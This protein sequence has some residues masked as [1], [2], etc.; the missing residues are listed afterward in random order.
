MNPMSIS[1]EEMQ[2]WFRKKFEDILPEDFLNYF[3]KKI[4]VKV[5]FNASKPLPH[6]Y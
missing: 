1:T 4:L 3:N 2:D 6:L 5:G